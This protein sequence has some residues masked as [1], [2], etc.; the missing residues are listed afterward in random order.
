MLR[1]RGLSRLPRHVLLFFCLFIVSIYHRLKPIIRMSIRGVSSS[2]LKRFVPSESIY[3]LVKKNP[4]I[5]SEFVDDRGC[6]PSVD[7]LLRS[8]V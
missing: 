1:W 5:G 3:F 7:N 8:K 4:A 6:T 2:Q